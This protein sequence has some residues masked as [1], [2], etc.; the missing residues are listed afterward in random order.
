MSEKHKLLCV[1]SRKGCLLCVHGGPSRG[2]STLQSI[3]QVNRFTEFALDDPAL[4]LCWN[5]LD[6]IHS[7]Y[8]FHWS[9]SQFWSVFIHGYCALSYGY[10][11][12][13]DS[14]SVRRCVSIE[15][16]LLKLQPSTRTGRSRTAATTDRT[17]GTAKCLWRSSSRRFRRSTW[18]EGTNSTKTVIDSTSVGE[19]WPSTRSRITATC[20][21]LCFPQI[22]LFRCISLC[23]PQ[24]ILFTIIDKVPSSLIMIT[25]RKMIFNS[26]LEGSS[27][28]N[29]V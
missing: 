23:L 18:S 4:D 5:T 1:K 10:I 29:S 21:E 13:I 7:T 22:I 28:I 17:A 27:T 14:Y 11:G 15:I 6:R 26:A 12:L 2:L 24:I 9:Y 19:S 16:L 20:I 8:S 25:R 3:L